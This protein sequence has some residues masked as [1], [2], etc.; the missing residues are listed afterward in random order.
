[1]TLLSY[2]FTI[3]IAS[4]STHP[5]LTHAYVIVQFG[6]AVS[7]SLDIQGL[8]P[9]SLTRHS[10]MLLY[11]LS[12]RTSCPSSYALCTTNLILIIHQNLLRVPSGES[13]FFSIFL[14]PQSSGMF[15]DAVTLRPGRLRTQRTKRRTETSRHRLGCRFLDMNTATAPRGASSATLG[16]TAEHPPSIFG[17]VFRAR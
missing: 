16:P 13:I 5:C 15:P 6:C 12:I 3:P 10:S 7:V 1:M 8:L 14:C 11:L 17:A 9:V 4:Y 2:L